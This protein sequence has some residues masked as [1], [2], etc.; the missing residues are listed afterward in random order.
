MGDS[1]QHSPNCLSL[2]QQTY[3]LPEAVSPP[4]FQVLVRSA[5]LQ[6]TVRGQRVFRRNAGSVCRLARE[7]CGSAGL[8]WSEAAWH[9]S[10]TAAMSG[11]EGLT[12]VQESAM[13][14]GFRQVIASAAAA[15]LEGLKQP[16]KVRARR[17]KPQSPS[18]I[19]PGK[20]TGND[21]NKQLGAR[22]DPHT[23][24]CDECAATTEFGL[25]GS[26]DGGKVKY[27]CR[28]HVESSGCFRVDKDRAAKLLAIG[29]VESNPGPV[30]DEVTAASGETR[31]RDVGGRPPIQIPSLRKVHPA[32]S[33]DQ[34]NVERI[35]A[36]SYAD[37]RKN[38]GL[39]EQWSPAVLCKLLMPSLLQ[40]VPGKPTAVPE[41]EGVV[42]PT[43]LVPLQEPHTAGVPAEVDDSSASTTVSSLE[44][45]EDVNLG[46]FVSWR[47]A[48]A[49]EGGS[50]PFRLDADEE[51]RG[52]APNP[53]AAGEQAEEL[54]P[55][56]RL[57]EESTLAG[58]LEEGP[59][60]PD[61]DPEDAS[62][63]I[64]DSSGETETEEEPDSSDLSAMDDSEQSNDD[65]NLHRAVDQT[66]EKEKLPRSVNAALAGMRL[67]T[68][69]R[70]QQEEASGSDRIRQSAVSD[71][72][73]GSGSDHKEQGAAH[74]LSQGFTAVPEPEIRS[75]PLT[76]NEVFKK[77][78]FRVLRVHEF[79]TNCFHQAGK[80]LSRFRETPE[81]G[82]STQAGEAAG[83][84]E[85]HGK[86]G[87]GRFRRE[88]VIEIIERW[89]VVVFKD[90]YALDLEPS[91]FVW[92]ESGGQTKFSLHLTINQL[93][94][95][96]LV[97]PSNSENGA[98]HFATHLKQ[99]LQ[100]WHPTIAPLIDLNVYSKDR[101]WRTPGSAK[102]EKPKSV[103][104]FL[105]PA[106]TWRDGLVTWLQSLEACEEIK[107]PFQ[108]PKN[109]HRG[110][111]TPQHMTREGTGRT[112]QNGAFVRARML[113][114]LR[115]RLHPTAYEEGPDRFNYFDRLEPCYTDRIHENHQNLTCHLTPNSKIYAL[116]FC[117]NV[118][119]GG[120]ESPCRTKAFYL[121]DLFED[122][123]TYDSGAV[124]VDMQYLQR[125][126][127]ASSPE[128]LS[129]VARGQAQ[130][131]NAF[132]LNTV[133]NEW[134]AG[135]FQLLAIRSAVNTG[136]TEFCTK[137]LKKRFPGAANYLDLKADYND[138]LFPDPDDPNDFQTA[139]QNRGKFPWVVVQV[140]SL[141]G[142]RPHGIGEVAPFDLVI[143]DEAASIL[144]H[145][146]SA[147]L[148]CGLETG[149]LFLEIVQ[150][151]KRVLAMDDGYG[152]RE[153][154]FFQL[155]RVPGKLVIN[156]RRAQVPLTFQVGKDEV[157][158]LDR[159]VDD[160]SA[161]KN[162]VVVSMSARILDR[163][164]DR[165]TSQ[166]VQDTLGL[167]P[168]RNILIHRAMSGGDNVELYSRT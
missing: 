94:P 156:M 22:S 106:H 103:L 102:V 32:P 65:P 121:G 77:D 13:L 96:Q 45:S 98:S 109:M 38:S 59:A 39:S 60:L 2:Q 112:P 141:L 161:N 145:L 138:E 43:T 52:M 26:K 40:A 53:T 56:D 80:N 3:G 149:E 157:R 41:S 89:A 166:G 11:L 146:S 67:E 79:G 139:L 105:K 4:E 68:E 144:A 165:V 62:E 46:K 16:G 155:A 148:R 19:P 108:L 142:L 88:E 64:E 14:E 85:E 167:D 162:V 31:P 128:L 120:S 152:Q 160:L 73:P 9:G 127:Q 153:H 118:E 132:K 104:R 134:L 135:A 50:E 78:E 18:P 158:W 147:T 113:Q 23:L 83:S 93:L 47:K 119:G 86:G 99:R 7:V 48:R 33:Q 84:V 133:A 17:A 92:L 69:R 20:H 101:E 61:E 81:T 143:L 117:T 123:I 6:T 95:R 21:C 164:R 75:E 76:G 125:D 90:S 54:T 107:L 34:P 70:R 87:E 129:E 91:S 97:F 36:A 55:V 24:H 115:E 66:R 8:D 116:C 44:D 130:A 100:P 72:D 35:Y 131:T 49:A 42:E 110:F 124:C 58:R 28:G 15:H 27:F 114:L 57:E 74:G 30:L 63:S 159:I 151:A 150:K 71:F 154:D 122:D 37:W 163:I 5:L 51:A 25:R 1:A 168:D 12:S 111:R 137:D 136:K 82:P 126:P 140:D 10:L 29:C